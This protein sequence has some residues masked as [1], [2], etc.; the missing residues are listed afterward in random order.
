MLNEDKRNA[1]E[2]IVEERPQ[3][4]SLR[5]AMATCLILKLRSAGDTDDEMTVDPT[6]RSG[7]NVI[8]RSTGLL[9]PEPSTPSG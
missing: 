5:T 4:E 2:I 9:D 6:A 3:C 1:V 7:A 8:P